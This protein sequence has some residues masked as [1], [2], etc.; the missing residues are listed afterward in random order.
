M[1]REVNISLSDLFPLNVY[2]FLRDNF[3]SNKWNNRWKFRSIVSLISLCVGFYVC[4]LSGVFVFWLVK[5]AFLLC[6]VGP[7]SRCDHLA[8]EEGANHLC[9][10]HVLSVLR[11]LFLLVSLVVYVLWL[12]H[13]LDSLCSILD[14]STGSK[15]IL[16]YVISLRKHA[17]SNILKFS[18]P[19]TVSFQ[20]KI[21]IFCMFLLITLIVGTR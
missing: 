17:Y 1:R 19:K 8:E 20:I 14:K 15:R 11:F 7:T 13:F 10:I 12:W 4:S 18:P 5:H 6:L 3:V 2:I 9:Y 21:L 16:E